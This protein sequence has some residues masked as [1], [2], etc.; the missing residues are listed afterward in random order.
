MDESARE[1]RGWRA[2]SRPAGDGNDSGTARSA[3]ADGNEAAGQPFGPSSRPSRRG[4]SADVR[5]GTAESRSAPAPGAATLEP[6][7]RWLPRRRCR[8][9]P[10]V[11]AS[12]MSM[13]LR[14]RIA[15]ECRSHAPDFDQHRHGE[16]VDGTA[17][18]LGHPPDSSIEFTRL[19]GGTAADER[20]TVQP[21]SL[22][23]ADHRVEC[24]TPRDPRNV[25]R[26]ERL[27]QQLRACPG[28]ELLSLEPS[29]PSISRTT[30]CSQ[31]VRAAS[32]LER[33]T[34]IPAGARSRCRTIP[35]RSAASSSRATRNREIP[36]SWAISLCWR[37]PGSSAARRAT[38]V[39][40]GAARLLPSDR[41]NGFDL[42]PLY[43]RA[44]NPTVWR[45]SRRAGVKS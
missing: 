22:D 39:T 35:S 12:G 3:R 7:I 42:L 21:G 27:R 13:V 1:R 30:A 16:G 19:E 36:K 23:D 5:D 44:A 18:A 25:V 41:F 9:Q 10:L 15:A 34:S 43:H 6:S 33:S 29:G 2:P 28:P 14:R 32:A 37:R 40:P 17:G 31:G 45:P 8:R 4:P 11:S 24:P 20:T 26:L 38:G